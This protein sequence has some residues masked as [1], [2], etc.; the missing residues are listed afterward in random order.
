M[1]P[2]SEP[3]YTNAKRAVGIT[4]KKKKLRLLRGLYPSANHP[5]NAA[6]AKRDVFCPGNGGPAVRA[7]VDLAHYPGVKSFPHASQCA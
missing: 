3:D 7:G 5:A 4:K 1:W 2:G 6:T